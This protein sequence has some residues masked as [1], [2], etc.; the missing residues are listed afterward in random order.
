MSMMGSNS[1]H[2]HPHTHRSGAAAGLI[3]GTRF[4]KLTP[5]SPLETS[6]GMGCPVNN[7]TTNTS[8]NT[9]T[10]TSPPEISVTIDSYCGKSPKARCPS[11]TSLTNRSHNTLDIKQ[12]IYPLPCTGASPNLCL[13]DDSNTDTTINNITGGDT[14]VETDPTMHI[15][16][17]VRC[18]EESGVWLSKEQLYGLLQRHKDISERVLRYAKRQR[19]TQE[20]VFGLMERFRWAAMERSS[21]RGG[22]DEGEGELEIE[23]E[24]DEAA[25]GN[26]LNEENYVEKVELVAGEPEVFPFFPDDS[27]KCT[28]V[29]DLRWNL[30]RLHAHWQNAEKAYNEKTEKMLRGYE[31]L[32][33]KQQ[34]LQ[35]MIEDCRKYQGAVDQLDFLAAR[36]WDRIET[37][38]KE[39]VQRRKAEKMLERWAREGDRVW[40]RWVEV[41]EVE[42]V[43]EAWR[44][45][46]D[47]SIHAGKGRMQRVRERTMSA[48]REELRRRMG[49]CRQCK[50]V[51]ARCVRMVRE[52]IR[53]EK[54]RKSDGGNLV[55][56]E[57]ERLEREISDL[58]EQL[59]EYVTKKV[60]MVQKVQVFERLLRRHA[61]KVPKWEEEL[62][63]EPSGGVLETVLIGMERRLKEKERE[64]TELKMRWERE[65]GYWKEERRRVEAELDR[66]RMRTGELE[67]TVKMLEGEWGM[68][69]NLESE[70][71]INPEIGINRSEQPAFEDNIANYLQAV[72]QPEVLNY[73]PPGPSFEPLPLPLLGHP[74]PPPPPHRRNLPFTALIRHLSPSPEFNR[75]K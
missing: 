63:E 73:G 70:N 42:M 31:E 62:E 41:R 1:P 8:T 37:R 44:A 72:T 39:I 27:L 47:E 6:S 66:E 3:L 25:G 22:D 64:V 18:S 7:N 32:A 49:R 61:L 24:Q 53:R 46:G 34:I 28:T 60:K 14:G 30:S 17:T 33:R 21:L 58:R 65:E 23:E 26:F 36:V 48:D 71:W 52:G 74:P 29:E 9:S 59:R 43:V 54:G 19:E 55:T 12:L 35:R 5:E 68:G 15:P 69:M 50:E 10:K 2:L 56:A 20:E 38:K 51:E 57:K 13:L 67:R 11:A 75:C 45:Y 40:R 4:L 16:H